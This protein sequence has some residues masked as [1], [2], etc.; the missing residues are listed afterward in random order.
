MNSD[1]RM[2][3][4]FAGA[5]GLK[6]F[7]QKEDGTFADAT[8]ATKLDPGVL[9]AD[10][11]GV[12]AADIEMDGDLDL[13]LGVR[14][15][16]VSVL[17]NNGDGTF[18]ALRCLWR[19][20]RPSRLRL[21]RPGRGRRP[22]RCITATPAA[23][24]ASTRTNA[25]DGSS[26]GP[27]RMVLALL[28]PWRSPTSIATA[29]LTCW[30]CARMGPFFGSRTGMTAMP[31]T[32]SRLSARPGPSGMLARLLVADLDN[33][34]AADLI[35]SGS[36]GGWIELADG[37]GGFRTLRRSGGPEVFDVADL[38]SDGLLDLAGL[39]AER[40]PARGLGRGTKDYHWQVIR[41]RG[42]RTFGD[43]RINSFGVG[44]EVEVR[45][46]L[47]YRSR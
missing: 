7:Q 21:G 11:F 45:A 32:W 38:N 6:I 24:C 37:N 9:G 20:N 39:S 40:R 12:W 35:G 14:Q 19:G 8:A 22:G 33:N 1:Y 47:L 3:L 27:I 43:G 23:A 17:R 30:R 5:G 41:P 15:G 31:G 2:D 25:P 28:R 10:A 36:S 16:K 44:G 13:V 26:R 42:A 4:V 29:S 46:G 18:S 34:G